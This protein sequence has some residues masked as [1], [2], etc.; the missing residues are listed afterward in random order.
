[1]LVNK[2]CQSRVKG[3]T[4]DP[5]IVFHMPGNKNPTHT[6]ACE[7]AKWKKNVREKCKCVRLCFLGLLRTAVK[8]SGG[9]AR[10]FFRGWL[11]F[12]GTLWGGGWNRGCLG[13]AGC[14]QVRKRSVAASWV[15]R[16]NSLFHTGKESCSPRGGICSRRWSLHWRRWPASSRSQSFSGTLW[17]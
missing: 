7:T 5:L 3:E 8:P 15:S 2:Y 10:G 4:E 14:W 13:L 6:L 1:M 12:R 9:V 11:C 17:W 16:G